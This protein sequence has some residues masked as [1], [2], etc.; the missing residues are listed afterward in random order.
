MNRT[1]S[2]IN[3]ASNNKLT[4]TIPT[5]VGKCTNLDQMSFDTNGLTGSIPMEI[6][7]VNNLYFI[8]LCENTAIHTDCQP[9]VP[10]RIL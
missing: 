8:Q 9:H 3:P 6:G 1:N 5:K 4:G 2:R 10:G 7:T